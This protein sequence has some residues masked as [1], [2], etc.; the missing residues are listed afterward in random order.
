M[1]KSLL[2]LSS[3]VCTALLHAQV[4]INT[5]IPRSTLTVN[6]SFAGQYKLSSA[7]TI[8]GASDYYMAFNGSTAA[9]FTLPAATAAAPAAGNIQGRVY[10]I[11]NTGS[12]QLTVAANGTELIDNQTGS[13]VANFK[14][15]PAGYAMLISR[16]TVSGTT[17]ELSTFI[18]KTTSTI[19][20]LGATDLVTYTGTA[21]TNFNNSVPQIVP[22][23]VGDMIVNQGGSVTWNDAGDYWQILESGVYKIEGYAYFGS[24]GAL[25]GTSQWTGIN[26]NITKNGTAISNIIGGN[27]GNIMDV[28]AQLGNTP[29]N[30]NC[31]VHLNAGDRVYLTMNYGA[32]DSPT[33]SVRIAVPNSLIE[34]RNFSMQQLSVP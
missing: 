27:R 18:D 15:N 30:V 21:F 28:I 22:F 20:A 3:F 2:Y 7:S 26:L 13:G 4:G 24:G 34:N 5:A 23:A 6:G 12:T 1:K 8:L 33:T 14:L 11:K 9:T 19:A 29:I 10:Y 25:S 16:G 32:G 17:W 31:I